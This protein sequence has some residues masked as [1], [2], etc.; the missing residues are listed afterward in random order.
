MGLSSLCV[1]LSAAPDVLRDGDRLEVEWIH[2]ARVATQV[3]E[4]Q[5][6]RYGSAGELVCD[7]MGDAESTFQ[8]EAAVATTT[9]P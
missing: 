8:L 3:V 6:G 2:A 4:G 9:V 5:T 7:L 1:A